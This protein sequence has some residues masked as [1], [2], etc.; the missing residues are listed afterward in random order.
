[1]NDNNLVD[2]EK[3]ELVI[4]NYRI[5]DPSNNVITSKRVSDLTTVNENAEPRAVF[6]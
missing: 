4:S 1:L 3:A 6:A 5:I 2:L